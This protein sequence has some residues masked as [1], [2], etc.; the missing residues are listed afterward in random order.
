MPFQQATAEG[1]V[2]SRREPSRP[3]ASSP[4]CSSALVVLGLAYLRFAPDAD[5]VSVPAGAQ[6]RRP[7]PE[8][9][10]YA[11]ENGSYAADCGTLVVPE[12]RADP[13]LA[14]D[15]AAGDPHPGPLGPP[16]AS[17]SSASR[18]APAS[19]T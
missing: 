14:A 12:N 3:R 10:H 2:A 15:R 16:G 19:R 9:V 8:A 7:D 11:T 6:G 5:A 18:A 4:S 1:R 17:R 13:Q